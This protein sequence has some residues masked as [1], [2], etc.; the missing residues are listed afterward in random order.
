M[1]RQEFKTLKNGDK[2]CHNAF[3]HRVEVIEGGLTQHGFFIREEGS[4]G[5]WNTINE[6]NCKYYSKAE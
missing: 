5:G 3:A 4:K 1:T 6:R 2:V